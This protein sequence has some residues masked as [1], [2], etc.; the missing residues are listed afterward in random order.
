MTPA[1]ARPVVVFITD[2][3]RGLERTCDV[4]EHAARALGPWR[5]A[6]QLRDKDDA[7]RRADWARVVRTVTREQRAFLLVN[8][9]VD[10]AI[11]IGADGAHVPSHDVTMTRARL[12]AAALVTTPAHVDDDVRRARDAAAAS[13]VLVSPIFAT[14]G[15]GKGVPRGTT[16]IESARVI[17][18]GS[19]L[20][21]LALGGV[22]APCVG[23][24]AA[25]GADGVAVIRALYDA[26]EPAKVARL[27]ADPWA[28]RL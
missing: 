23:A 19:Q 2:P 4:I 13:A 26:D 10:L 24:C 28:R 8:G 20:A 16:A 11:A 21:I 17:A 18:A 25:A 27:L 7:A 5:L 9:D 3:T 14:P 1:H 15:E 12:G 6:V 22:D